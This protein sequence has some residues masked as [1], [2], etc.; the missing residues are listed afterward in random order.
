M[1]GNAGN[2][3]KKTTYLSI[4]FLHIQESQVIYRFACLILNY[5]TFF[6]HNSLSLFHFCEQKSFLMKLLLWR[7]F[8]NKYF[9]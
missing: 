2:K 5:N 4:K 3:F 7:E 8:K 6:L 1:N 9:K